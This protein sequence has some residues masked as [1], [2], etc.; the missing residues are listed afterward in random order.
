MVDR[1]EQQHDHRH[2]DE[3]ERPPL[4]VK[5]DAAVL[6][7]ESC[8]HGPGSALRAG[9]ADRGNLARGVSRPVERRV[10]GGQCCGALGSGA[11]RAAWGVSPDGAPS[12]GLG[13]DGNGWSM[14]TRPRSPVVRCRS[15]SRG[16]VRRSCRKPATARAWWTGSFPRRTFPA[17]TPSRTSSSPPANARA[18]TRA[19]PAS[20]GLWSSTP[21][22]RRTRRR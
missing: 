5:P 1:S 15:T 21:S 16:G 18:T 4:G 17:R 6:Q 19:W 3:Q 10:P 8:G 9:P 20:A 22:G 12:S 14:S 11:G 2:P 13:G 7:V